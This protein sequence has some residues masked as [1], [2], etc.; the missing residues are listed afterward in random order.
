[1]LAEVRQHAEEAI[2]VYA[3][4]CWM[5]SGE[6]QAELVLAQLLALNL[7][8]TVG[9]DAWIANSMNALGYGCDMIPL[10]RVSR[11]YHAHALPL[12]EQSAV[13]FTVATGHLL[14]GTHQYWATGD[15]V[16]ALANLNAGRDEFR[17]Q[18]RVRDWGGTMVVG[19]DALFDRGM[20]A[21]AW[22][23][24][25]ETVRTGRRPATA[26]WRAGA[27]R[28]GYIDLRRS[29]FDP[30]EDELREAVDLLAGS[31][32]PAA[33]ATATGWLAQSY[34]DQGELDEARATLAGFVE[35]IR[36]YGIR[37]YYL[38]SLGPA[39]AMLSLVRAEE[40]QGDKTGAALKEAR[41]A[42]KTLRKLAKADISALVA[43][44][45]L[46]GTLPVG[47]GPPREGGI[48]VEEEFEPRRR[49]SARATKEP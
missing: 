35:T 28:T 31:A 11:F 37:G 18:G 29:C 1:M 5:S 34:L 2:V 45:R 16:S 23:R 14:L 22:T 6:N 44:H 17:T 20:S 26:L 13:P 46:Q 21:D 24:A 38:R 30:A 39:Q 3:N 25:L 43:T 42:C 7:A 9:L 36:K 10:P 40:A 12:A 19:I 49:G 41:A 47:S 4:L 8:E 33:A 27:R 32:Q 15:W 48:R